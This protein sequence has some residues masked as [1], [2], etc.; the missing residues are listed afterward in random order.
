MNWLE[1]FGFGAL[2]TSVGI[3]IALLV[4]AV[5]ELK[6]IRLSIDAC[7]QMV[8]DAAGIP[9]TDLID[10]RTSQP[11]SVEIPDSYKELRASDEDREELE[12]P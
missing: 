6:A 3:L 10:I 12:G 1:P 7:R 9:Q 11:G 2:A 4:A 5:L 8:S